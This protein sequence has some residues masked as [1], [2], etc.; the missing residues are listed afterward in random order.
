[1]KI[2]KKMLGKIG[3]GI[4]GFY[5]NGHR[6]T[7]LLFFGVFITSVSAG[8]GLRTKFGSVRIDNVIPGVVYNTREI[9]NLP[10]TVTNTGEEDMIGYINV[11]IPQKKYCRIGFEPIEDIVWVQLS[12]DVIN[13]RPGAAKTADIIIRIPDKKEYYDRKFVVYIEAAGR[14]KEG[15]VATGVRSEIYL[16]TVPTKEEKQKRE[17]QEKEKKEILAN[18]NYEF[19]PGK[20]F[21][22]EIKPGKRCDVGKEAG[23]TLKIV[24]MN[25]EKYRYKL[26]SV[27]HKEAKQSIW[28]GYETAPD[29]SWLTFEKDVYKVDGNTIFPVKAFI[30]IPKGKEHYGKRYQFFIKAEL[31]DQKIP[32]SIY[33]Y[34]MVQMQEK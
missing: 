6:L 31:L 15:N 2:E 11:L 1:M 24:N 12:E 7:A 9:V 20:I 23:K 28:R 3:A 5:P 26:I 16:T 25:D 21:L 19:L 13:L 33:S 4:T 27:S 8:V 17:K 10:Y 18:L 22:F 32:V 29:P 14:A 34:V 30:K